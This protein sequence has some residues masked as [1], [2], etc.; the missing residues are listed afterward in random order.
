[1]KRLQ[2]PDDFYN[3]LPGVLGPPGRTLK[4][5][6]PKQTKTNYTGVMLKVNSHINPRVITII[7]VDADDAVDTIN[8][9]DAVDTINTIDTIN[10]VDAVDTVNTVDTADTIMT[11]MTVD[12][13]DTAHDNRKTPRANNH[14]RK[15]TTQLPATTPASARTK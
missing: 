1:M 14:N 2:L 9:V 13:F 7:A 10:A 8:A 11:V 5:K 6:Q 15:R 3:D 12:T 4:S